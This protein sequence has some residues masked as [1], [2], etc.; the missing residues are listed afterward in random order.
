MTRVLIYCALV[1]LILLSSAS[2]T[3][4]RMAALPVYLSPAL[5]L[6]FFF[7]NLA[8]SGSILWWNSPARAD[9]PR[10][11]GYERLWSVLAAWILGAA[12]IFAMLPLVS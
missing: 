7:C 11:R 2:L 3:D 1:C 4:A 8:I 10:R 5:T 6:G 12:T 9:R